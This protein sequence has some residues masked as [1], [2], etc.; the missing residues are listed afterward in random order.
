ML[1]VFGV[2]VCV[3]V[4]LRQSDLGVDNVKT[5][6]WLICWVCVVCVAK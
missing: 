3:N 2:S 4:Y 1:M 6:M 5:R